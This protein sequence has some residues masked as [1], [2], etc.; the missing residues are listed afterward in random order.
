MFL[1]F[2]CFYH[3]CTEVRTKNKFG[4]IFYWLVNLFLLLIYHIL[5]I[6]YIF[7]YILLYHVFNPPLFTSYDITENYDRP[8]SHCSSL[9]SRTISVLDIWGLVVDFIVSF[10][11]CRLIGCD[12]Y[13]TLVF[14]TSSLGFLPSFCPF[15]LVS[16][17]TYFS[18]SKV[19][20]PQL[21][22]SGLLWCVSWWIF[23]S[24]FYDRVGTESRKRERT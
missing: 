7:T 15:S 6:V 12:L 8:S 22:T 10:L 5:N 19:L 16:R 13:F 17:L 3:W 21:S 11:N 23:T 14:L 24:K 9:P 2:L 20:F 4:G 1:Y 18:P